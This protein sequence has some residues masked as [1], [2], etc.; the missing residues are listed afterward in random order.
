MVLKLRNISVG[1]V[2]SLNLKSK[3]L[4]SFFK[5]NWSN[6]TILQMNKFYN[7]QFVY[8]NINN[9]NDEYIVALSEKKEICGV[10]GVNSRK[11]WLNKKEYSGGELTT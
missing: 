6:N 7:W 3:A 2:H 4:M 9:G 11:F 10:M 5:N 8:N 1:E